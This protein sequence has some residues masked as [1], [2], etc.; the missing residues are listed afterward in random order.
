MTYETLLTEL[1]EGVMTVTLNR[2]DRLNAFNT[3]MSKEL[4][5]FL[6]SVNA[7]D[8][9]RSV[10]VTGAGRAFCAG[11][12][13]SA[14]SAA[15]QVWSD[16]GAPPNREASHASGDQHRNIDQHPGQREP[17]ARHEIARLPQ[18]IEL[19]LVAP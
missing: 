2:P 15:F 10:V 8:Q 17:P 7:M 5:D 19:G 4:I 6:Q 1:A 16:G 3:A 11:A 14:G 13:I 12:D 9:V 18:R